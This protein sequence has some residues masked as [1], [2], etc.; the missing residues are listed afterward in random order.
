EDPQEEVVVGPSHRLLGAVDDL[1]DDRPDLA[2]EDRQA[3]RD[4]EQVVVE[5]RRLARDRRLEL[6]PGAEERQPPEDQHER[7]ERR[8]DDEAE[9]PAADRALGKAVDRLD[10]ARARQEGAKNG[11]L[12]RK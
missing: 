10:H 12:E 3:E 8:E 1:R 11:E 4:E 5:E 6:R 7:K 9:E 2:P